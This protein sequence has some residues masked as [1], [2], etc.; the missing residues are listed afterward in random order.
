MT[1]K[2]KF[3]AGVDYRAPRGTPIPAQAPGEVV[4]SGFND[5]YGNT[6]IVKTTNGYGLYAHMDEPSHARMGDRIWPGDIIGHVGSTGTFPTGNHLHY[7]TIKPLSKQDQQALGRVEA[8]GRLG[9]MSTNRI[10]KTRTR[11]IRLSTIRTRR[12]RRAA[13]WSDRMTRTMRW[14]SETTVVR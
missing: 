14:R 7:S 5:G 12:L 8:P 11:S 4:Y 2:D 6:V 1:H 9:S 3:H 10:R 13:R